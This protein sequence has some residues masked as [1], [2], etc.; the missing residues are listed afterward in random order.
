MK[1]NKID[2]FP[3]ISIITPSLNQGEFLEDCIK[4]ILKQTCKNYEHIV[5]DGI[6]TD[7]TLNILKKYKHIKWISE[8]DSGYWDGITKGI[9]MSKGKYI[10]I[11]MASDGYQNRK[12]LQQCLDVLEKDKEVALVWGFPI[13]LEDNRLTDITYPHFHRNGAPQKFDWFPYWLMTGECLP[14][15]DFCIRKDV[16]KKC[17]SASVKTPK[18]QELFDLN[19]NFNAWG[20]LPF[21]IPVVAEF[22][23]EHPG[24]IGRSWTENG[25]IP[26]AI[27]R[28]N[29]QIR[30]YRNDL[31]NGKKKHIFRDSNGKILIQ[32]ANLKNVSMFNIYFLRLKIF[33]PLLMQRLPTKI[34]RRFRNLR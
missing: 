30:D 16:F 8:K 5:V 21:N 14:N 9:K 1:K 24:Q 6:S 7:N 13:W 32:K 12:W 3:L 22:G 15:G 10:M 27:K 4:S 23:R 31:L 11:C 29:N 17:N 34:K 18:G 25:W 26:K 2:K 20:Y 28:Y 19:Y 33:L